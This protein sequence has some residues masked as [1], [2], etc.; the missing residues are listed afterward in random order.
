MPTNEKPLWY[1]TDNLRPIPFREGGEEAPIHS[2]QQLINAL[3]NFAAQKPRVLI[4]TKKDGPQLF[5]GLAGELAGVRVYPHPPSGR[6]WSAT[7][8]MPYSSE[9][10]WITSEGEPSLFDAATAMPVDDV[11]AIVAHVVE[12]GDLPDS[13]AWINHKGEQLR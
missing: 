8:K 12:H 7:P 4:L 13:V 6:S 5:I 11:I 9:D 1:L 3:R 2:V 10:L